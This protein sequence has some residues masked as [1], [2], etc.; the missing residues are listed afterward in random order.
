M[1]MNS[2]IIKPISTKT[3]LLSV[4]IAWFT[5]GIAFVGL[6]TTLQHNINTSSAAE[7][8]SLMVFAT[9]ATIVVYVESEDYKFHHT[10]VGF[11]LIGFAV[12]CTA[13]FSAYALK[14]SFTEQVMRSDIFDAQKFNLDRDFDQS[15]THMFDS[16]TP[17][18]IRHSF[19]VGVFD[20]M[21]KENAIS[22]FSTC[23]KSHVLSQISLEVVNQGLPTTG[24]EPCIRPTREALEKVDFKNLLVQGH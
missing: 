19:F 5:L 1:N 6:A 24:V 16:R 17:D 8:I 12:L 13:F 3:L 14:S 18:A 2:K 4:R 10:K 20:A 21:S 9:A 7:L 23:S 11:I 15:T 22:R